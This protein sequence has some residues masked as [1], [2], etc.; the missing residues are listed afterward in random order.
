MRDRKHRERPVNRAVLKITE[1]R[2]TQRIA[3]RFTQD[4]LNQFANRTWDHLQQQRKQNSRIDSVLSAY[5]TFYGEIVVAAGIDGRVFAMYRDEL[6]SE[7]AD[8]Y[9]T[10]GQ[11]KYKY[12]TAEWNNYMKLVWQ[13]TGGERDK[14]RG[15]FE[16]DPNNLNLAP[17]GE[18]RV[19]LSGPAD[20]IAELKAILGE[21][22]SKK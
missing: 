21:E 5:R 17:L 22:D 18:D 1:I 10:F 11:N 7:V 4:E 6:P 16:P 9:R 13:I 3:D 20:V 19:T 2:T 12:S 15:T 8:H 14:L